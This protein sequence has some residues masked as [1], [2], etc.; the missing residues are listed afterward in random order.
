MVLQHPL[1]MMTTRPPAAALRLLLPLVG[2]APRP[3]LPLPIA[4]AAAAAAMVV[5]AAAPQKVW[6]QMRLVP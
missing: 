4:Q 5:A 1:V 2:L 6:L 3:M